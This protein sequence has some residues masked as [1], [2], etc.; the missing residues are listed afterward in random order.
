MNISEINK[1]LGNVTPNYLKEGISI[2][3][4]KQKIK[5]A[6]IVE[7]LPF[8]PEAIQI[9]RL[10]IHRHNLEVRTNY[11][12]LAEHFSLNYDRDPQ[13]FRRVL[14]CYDNVK[15]R[16]DAEQ[17]VDND[18]LLCLPMFYTHGNPLITNLTREQFLKNSCEMQKQLL[19][20]SGLTTED[21]KTLDYS[22]YIKLVNKE[23]AKIEYV[24]KIAVSLIKSYKTV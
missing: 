11:K 21:L 23:I 5:H 3:H 9:D 24:E 4:V 14:S 8:I 22:D 13:Y 7:Y 17:W 16:L 10:S 2:A 18:K 12:L 1:L 6:C 15:F 20:E 19:I